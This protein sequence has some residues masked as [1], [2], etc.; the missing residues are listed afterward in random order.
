MGICILNRLLVL[1]TKETLD[2][3]QTIFSASPFTIHWDTLCVEIGSSEGPIIPRDHSYY[4]AITGNMRTWYEAAS[5]KSHL[6][7]P[8]IPSPEMVSRH[9]EV[10]DGW[11]REFFPYMALIEDPIQRRERKAFLNSIATRFVDFPAVLTFHNEIVVSSNDEL[12]PHAEFYADHAKHGQTPTSLF[13]DLV[14]GG[15]A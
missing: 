11:G 13:N 15:G 12:P 7:L 2:L 8:L 10:G 3:L 5:G 14:S 6:L 4:R 9:E 1:P